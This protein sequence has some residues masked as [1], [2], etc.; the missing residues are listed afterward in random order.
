MP[1]PKI[2]I[3]KKFILADGR[4]FRFYSP[5]YDGRS[6]KGRPKPIVFNLE[7]VIEYNKHG[8]P[9]PI[10]NIKTEKE[11]VVFIRENFGYGEYW[12]YGML[13]G[14]SGIWTFWRGA[15]E[16]DGWIF[17]MRDGMR[18]E[19]DKIEAELLN[20]EPEQQEAIRD[21]LMQE[22]HSERQQA[23]KKR[24]GFYPFLRAS[25]RRGQ[26]NMWDEPDKAFDVQAKAKTERR[27][28]D[29]STMT[30][31]EINSFE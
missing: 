31:D 12:V 16:P 21:G 23:R 5:L 7:P 19:A 4:H 27:N 2:A 24:Y 22:L 28:V 11:L 18:Q 6:R 1:R 26:F 29:P 30:L 9:Y 3:M 8:D 10:L 13:K 17:T 25:G 20:F 15:L 14:R